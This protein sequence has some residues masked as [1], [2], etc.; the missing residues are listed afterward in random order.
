ML[1]RK[2]TLFKGD[3]DYAGGEDSN[4]LLDEQITRDS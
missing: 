3:P 1:K 2:Q 4:N